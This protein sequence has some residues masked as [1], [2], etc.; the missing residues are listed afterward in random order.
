MVVPTLFEKGLSPEKVFRIIIIVC[1]AGM[2]LAMIYVAN[3]V[4]QF[5]SPALRLSVYKGLVSYSFAGL[6]I[7]ILFYA[8]YRLVPRYT[9]VALNDRLGYA[10]SLDEIRSNGKKPGR[11][12]E[13]DGFRGL[14]IL[15][16][17]TGHLL[18]FSLGVGQ[19]GERMGEMGV[20]LFFVLS[21]YLITGLLRDEYQETGTIN[22]WAFYIRRAFRL[23]PPLYLFLLAVAVLGRLDIVRG[24]PLKDFAA[25][26]LYVRNIFGSSQSLGHLWSLS[27]EEQFYLTWPAIFL[28]SGRRRIFRI[29]LAVVAAVIAWRAAAIALTLGDY[30]SGVFYM[31]PWYRYDAIA[32]GCLLALMKRSAAPAALLPITAL[33]LT[34]WCAYGEILFRPLYI[35]GQ[36]ILSVTLLWTVV[37][38]PVAVRTG[39]SLGWLRWLGDISYSLYLWQQIFLV[40]HAVASWVTGFILAMGI[41]TLSHYW[42]ELPFI[43]YGRKLTL[44]VK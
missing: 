3:H 41:A 23:L 29:G 6:G 17:V 21:G 40:T 20:L 8:Q 38:G 44:R 12:P 14:A 30:N 43:Q 26:V 24:V 33:L 15:L 7:F 22:L 11:I 35:T 36:T 13:L 25:A 18:Q 27:L 4:A 1:L 10:Q 39:F 9:E 5:D 28:L 42:V 16:V 37:A 31:R 32:V 19:L 34:G 2:G